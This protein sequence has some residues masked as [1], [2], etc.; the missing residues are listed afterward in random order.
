MQDLLETL[1]LM[2]DINAD[3]LRA[4]ADRPA[5][6][7]II[8]SHIDKGEGAVATLLVQV[9]TL[10]V[11]DIVA[12]SGAYFG[13]IR[14]LKDH[15]G[16]SLESVGPGTPAKIL[17]LKLAPDVG[18]IMEVSADMKLLTRDTKR[19]RQ[20]QE[21]EVPMQSAASAEKNESTL[22][23]MV[24]ADVLGSVEAIIESLAKLDTAPIAIRVISKGLGAITEADVLNAE[25]TGA[26]LISFHIKPTIPAAN[27]A[28]DKEVEILYYEVIYHLIEEVERR[29]KALVK[30]DIKRILIGTLEVLKVFRREAGTT[31]LG[32]RVTEGTIAPSEIVIIV[33]NGEAVASGTVN[34]LESGRQV[35]DQVPTG[36]ECGVNFVGKGT[37]EE[38]DTLEFYKEEK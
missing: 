4:E 11:G 37:I 29:A 24:K 7:T 9:G 12:V 21:R 22:T 8:E 14:S 16:Q 23:L 10:R 31:I 26:I 1:L 20:Q 27:L 19:Q 6:G 25:A 5:I 13:K 18:S 2:A 38:K 34:R 17:G 35:T 36:T 3:Q 28:R 30:T 15:R 33:R 32:G